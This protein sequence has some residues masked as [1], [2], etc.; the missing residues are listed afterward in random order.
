MKKG[1]RKSIFDEIIK[2]FH[3]IKL[4]ILLL[5]VNEKEKMCFG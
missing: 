2:P 3:G 4:L 1:A 5:N